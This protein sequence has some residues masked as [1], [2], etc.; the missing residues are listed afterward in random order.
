MRAP[1][2]TNCSGNGVQTCTCRF[3]AWGT[4]VACT[5]KT[6]GAAPGTGSCA[7]GQTT[8]SGNGYETCTASGAWSAATAC[9]NQTCVNGACTGTCAP[10]PDELLGWQPAWRRAAR[11]ARGRWG[12]P[13]ATRPACP[14]PAPACARPARRT[15]R[16]ATS[17]RR[18]ARRAPG[19]SEP[20][21]ATR[22]AWEGHAPARAR[23][24]RRPA[25]ATASR[26]ATRAEPS[27]RPQRVP[28]RPAWPAP[29]PARARRARRR[30]SGNGVETCTASGTYGTAVACVNQDVRELALARA[31]A[32]RA[33]PLARATGSRP[34]PPAAR[35]APPARAPTCART[36]ACAGACSPGARQCSGNGVADLRLERAVG[37]RASRA[38][39]RR[40]SAA[41][42]RGPAP[43]A[44]RSARAT[45]CRPATSNRAPGAPPAACTNQACVGGGCT[46]VCAPGPDARC[47]GNGGESATRAEHVE[48]ADGLLRT[49][50]A[51]RI[52]HRLCAP[53]QVTCSGNSTEVVQSN[54]AF[55]QPGRVQQPDVRH[56]RLR[57]L[58]R[59]RPDAVL[60]QRRR[61]VHR[62]AGRGAPRGR[63]HEPDLR[64][65]I[66]HRRRARRAR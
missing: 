38:R 19:R 6:C 1:G 30:R 35:G 27:G 10:R 7:P 42:A 62:P 54:G 53:G 46:G 52:L 39:I 47:S 18:A 8:C 61:D 48:R 16:A 4:A 14:V 25:R 20:R 43:R 24:A 15:A 34:A 59:A 37:H 56:G 23:P 17:P 65:R 55:G 13:A 32:R 41:S 28:T 58:V 60:R 12:R 2:Q 29:A 11:R 5:N 40:A 63:V 49:R 51:W 64:G 22:R 66:L 31:S 36:G 3:Y 44:R 9:S 57:R 50:P 33:R 21:A 26:R 45:A